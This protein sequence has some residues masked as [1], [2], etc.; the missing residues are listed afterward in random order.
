MHLSQSSIKKTLTNV[1]K[2]SAKNWVFDVEDGGENLRL[3]R[4]LAAKVKEGGV[5]IIFFGELKGRLLGFVQ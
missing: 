3:V 1:D 4:Q 5:S 2:K